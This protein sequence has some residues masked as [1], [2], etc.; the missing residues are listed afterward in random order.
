MKNKYSSLIIIISIVFFME[1]IINNQMVYK[2]ISSSI[3]IWLNVLIPSLFPFFI[4]SDIPKKIKTFLCKVFKI[5]ENSLVIFLLS[6]LSGFPSNARN[7]RT[8]YDKGLITKEE[9][10]HILMFTHFSNPLFILTTVG[11]AFFN[12][13]KLGLVILISHYVSNIILGILLRN[14]SPSN[15]A[16][17]E[18]SFKKTKLNFGWVLTNSIK[19]ALDTLFLIFGTLTVFL[20]IASIIINRFNV[21]SYGSIIIKGIL[22][23]T[24]GL[25]ELSLLNLNS[26]YVVVISSMMISFGGLSVHMQVI[27]QLVGTDISYRNFFWGRIYQMVISGVLASIFY[28]IIIL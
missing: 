18:K 26:L 17:S 15:Y 27:S 10:S 3:D 9:A 16:V 14:I 2:T 11:L 13:K 21:S 19:H 8:M 6:L 1:I 28:Y 23:I 4:I 12:N 20:V 22:E 24:M 25:Q 7:T 5:R